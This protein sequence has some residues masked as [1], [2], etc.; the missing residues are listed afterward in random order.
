MSP[1]FVHDELAALDDL[2]AAYHAAPVEEYAGGRI[3]RAGLQRRRAAVIERLLV[4]A[5]VDARE[6]LDLAVLPD[7]D[8][9][10][11]GT[12]VSVLAGLLGELQETVS[13]LAQSIKDR[14]TSR[15]VV[16]GEIQEA[17]RLQVA[18]AVPGSLTVHLV[19]AS[20]EHQQPLLEDAIETL[21]HLSVDALIGLLEAGSDEGRVEEFVQRLSDAGPRASLHLEKLSTLLVNHQTKTTI[22]WRSSTVTRRLAFDP[23]HA[24][25]V[26]TV[27]KAAREEERERVL[28]GRLVGGSLVRGSFEFEL[29]DGTVLSGKALE[30]AMASFEAL[31]GSE[32][33]ATVSVR[34]TSLASGET[35]EAFL[36]TQ[37]AP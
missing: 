6:S 16:P 28:R 37:L 34:E 12:D 18:F 27:L 14:P 9:A 21:L 7:N 26:A 13:A 22:R 35:R 25:Q 2:L 11:R 23:R 3:M 33:T 10:G 15:G 29:P 19:P 5:P 1:D 17:V 20:P 31:F 30:V 8:E 32:C 36:L 4:A 24:A